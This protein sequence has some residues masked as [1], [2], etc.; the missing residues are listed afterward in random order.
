MNVFNSLCV[1]LLFY[2]VVVDGK[3]RNDYKFYEAAGGWFKLHEVPASWN[4][5]WYKCFREGAVL[6]SPENE[7]LFSTMKTLVAE[8]T[9]SC[10]VYTGIHATFSKGDYYS[11]EGTPLSKIPVFWAPDE[12]DNF[13]NGEDCIVMLLNG[14]VADV[15]CTDVYPFLCFKKKTKNMFTSG[16]GTV[17][18]GY[19]FD[20]RT[21]SCYKF[22]RLPQTWH[23]AFAACSGEG[24]H[25]A[26]INSDLEAQVIK[27]LYGKNP[28]STMPGN[29]VKHSSHIGHCDWG[30]RGLWLTIHG[31]TLKEAGYDK[32]SNGEP[33]NSTQA[34]TGQYCGAVHRPGTLNDVWCNMP[35]PFICEKAPDSLVDDE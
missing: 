1:F 26:I 30:E 27:E 5:A 7:N 2:G 6:A 15:Q 28:D 18:T 33:A 8:H 32:W 21:G 24:G 12:P 20:P 35:T 17:D 4:N 13:Q 14:T 31:Q 34:S 29:F 11:I 10:G 19:T 9:K 22:H 23:R 3:F 16:C 25:L